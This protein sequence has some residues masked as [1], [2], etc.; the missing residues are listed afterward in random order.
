MNALLVL[1]AGLL[2]AAAGS[3]W[4][5][6]G[7]DGSARVALVAVL[8]V[9]AAS[10]NV[11]VP[12]PSVEATTMVTLCT[13][14]ALGARTGAAAGLVAVVASSV[15]GGVGAWTAWQVVAV[16]VVSLV[17]A[18]LAATGRDAD[19]FARPRIALLAV[20]ALA[21]TICWDLIVTA[22]G[23]LTYAPASGATP[24]DQLLAAMLIGMAFT[25]THAVFTTAFTVLAGPPLLHALGRARPRLDGGIVAP[26]PHRLATSRT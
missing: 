25:V 14:I 12:V 18:A 21:A 16:V 20:G 19:W 13:A 10:F 7:M 8:G 11:L 22:G 2:L 5:T 3:W 26:D 1:C 4:S 9:L 6:R 23:V 24:L 15:S 17:G